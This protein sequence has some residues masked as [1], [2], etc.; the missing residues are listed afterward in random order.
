MKK[1]AIAF[2]PDRVRLRFIIDARPS[3]PDRLSL[4]YYKS[5]KWQWP[6]IVVHYPLSRCLL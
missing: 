3:T 4:E 1:Q 5:S 2:E 6:Y